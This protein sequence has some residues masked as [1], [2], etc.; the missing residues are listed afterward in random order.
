MSRAGEH[1][2]LPLTSGE[3]GDDGSQPDPPRDLSSR[4]GLSCGAAHRIVGSL[5]RSL[6]ARCAGRQFDDAAAG[7]CLLPIFALESA[8]LTLTAGNLGL[9]FA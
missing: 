1:D 3:R 4:L 9:V 7:I 5:K 6:N 8:A 2:T